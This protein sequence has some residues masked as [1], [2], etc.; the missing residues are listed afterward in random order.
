MIR[1]IVILSFLTISFAWCDVN[2]L[3]MQ[4]SNPK[5]YDEVKIKNPEILNE[6]QREKLKNP[7]QTMRTFIET[8]DKIKRGLTSSFDEA[9]LTLDLSEIDPG[10]KLITGKI[11]S[12]RLI[13]SIDRIAKINFKLIPSYE[14]GPKWYFRKQSVSVGEKTYD[15]EISLAK[16]NSGVWRFTP[17]TVSSIDNFYTS[18]AKLKVVDGVLEYQNWRSQFKNQMPT[19]TAEEFLILKKG[20]WL[21][22]I[23]LF[24]IGLIFLGLVRYLIMLYLGHKVNQKVLDFLSV[25]Q[26]KSTLPFGLLA[27]SIIWHIGL[28][29]LEFDINALE[30]FMRTSYVMIA[31]FMVWSALKIVD[32]V[33]L[34]FEKVSS[35]KANKFDDV[36]IPMLKTTSKVMVVSF[37]AILVA[38]SLAFDVASIWAGLGIGGVAVA[39]AAKDTISNLFGS[40]TVLMDRP[41]QIGDYITLE[42]NIEGAVEQVGFRSTRLRTPYNSL[43]TIPNSVLANMAIDNYGM[44]RVRR[45]KTFLQFDYSTSV[46]KIEEF[47]QKVH[48]I[49]KLNPLIQKD[50]AIVSLYEMNI[51][52]IDVMVTIFFVTEDLKVELLERHKFISEVLKIANE[53]KVTF[54]FNRTSFFQPGGNIPPG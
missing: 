53:L 21:S 23:F 28:R 44:R 6:Y 36:L 29:F 16:T 47:C 8:M 50:N 39:L 22:L 49:I 41:F 11:T 1:L 40:V 51:N 19:W 30:F 20:Q 52:S 5:K 14:E 3:T 46:E 34:H 13:N 27:F 10:L 37:G 35:N 45:Y 54:C 15:V 2:P 38:H 31:L 17:E 4:I 9:I 18:M 7:A 33:S 26:F 32:Y 42:K 24:V 25:D 12:E 43:V 48:Y